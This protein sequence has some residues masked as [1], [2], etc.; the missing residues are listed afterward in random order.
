MSRDTTETKTE[1]N[2]E[3]ASIMGKDIEV[4]TYAS[5]KEATKTVFVLKEQMTESEAK[6]FL[7]D[8]KTGTEHQYGMPDV[9]EALLMLVE[10]DEL[11][12]RLLPE[13]NSK[14]MAVDQYGPF[15]AIVVGISSEVFENNNVCP[16]SRDEKA[17]LVM[18][19]RR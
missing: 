4:H 12:A 10:S 9:F 8:A 16:L 7:R 15:G 6:S 13:D 1:P 5:G 11:E 17:T 18:L 19:M 14:I 2:K 3:A